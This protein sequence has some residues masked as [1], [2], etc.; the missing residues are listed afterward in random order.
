[1]LYP[2]PH[3]SAGPQCS[4]DRV[5]VSDSR[6]GGS[7]RLA[8]FCL[9]YSVDARSKRPVGEEPP[10]QRPKDSSA[11]RAVLTSEAVEHPAA[12]TAVCDNA[13][14]AQ[15][16]QMPGYVRLREREQRLKMTDA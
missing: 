10:S 8:R 13:G 4:V 1:M 6:P 2:K 11:I 5:V 15:N 7:L 9:L 16:S 3:Q 14:E 12:R